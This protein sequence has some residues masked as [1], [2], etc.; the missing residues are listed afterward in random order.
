MKT[1]AEFLAEADA[2]AHG[3]LNHRGSFIRNRFGQTHK[4][5]YERITG[6]K[7]HPGDY[8]ATVDHA[9]RRGW[10]RLDINHD[11]KKGEVYGLAQYDPEKWTPRHERALRRVKAA[12][13]AGGAR[14]DVFRM[15]YG[16]EQ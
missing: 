1:L 11:A 5:T 10:A 15:S 12:L 13:R 8:D 14:D 7:P 4:K 16:D 6:E 9:L 2:Y 3:W